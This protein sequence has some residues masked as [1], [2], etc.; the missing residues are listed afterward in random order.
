[1]Q[2]YAHLQRE[3]TRPTADTLQAYQESIAVLATLLLRFVQQKRKAI[4][5]VQK[6]FASHPNQHIFASLPGASELL[7]PKLL[8][9]F[10][11]QRERFPLPAAIQ[12]LA[13]TCPIT[14]QS[15][16]KRSIRF[17]ALAIMNIGTRL[18]SL[19]LA[20]C[21]NRLGPTPT[22]PW[23]S[24]VACLRAMLIAT[25]GLPLSGRYGKETNRTM[26]AIIWLRYSGIAAPSRWREDAYFV[27]EPLIM[28]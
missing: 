28:L 25:V 26:K 5:R 20:P 11:D 16:K 23:P 4:R 13:G 24:S 19:P 1:M 8:V 12:A 2:R 27:N 22:S 6:L 3:I 7:A 9:M 15:G 14:V 17:R 18:N 21:S 10:G